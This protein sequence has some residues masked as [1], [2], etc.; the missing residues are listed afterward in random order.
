M[1]IIFGFLLTWVLP[2]LLGAGF[3]W[4]S[5]K[6]RGRN[7]QKALRF[8]SMGF[9]TLVLRPFLALLLPLLFPGPIAFLIAVASLG[10]PVC[11]FL[12]AGNSLLKEMRAQQRG[13]NT[14]RAL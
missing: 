9:W 1:D 6:V 10:V 8:T 4:M 2:I 3:W 5:N 7:G 11:F 13:D 12:A 14:E